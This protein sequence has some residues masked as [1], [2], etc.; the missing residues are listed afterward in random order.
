MVMVGLVTALAGLA[1]PLS[2]RK[3][4]VGSAPKGT[5]SLN[6]APFEKDL[7]FRLNRFPSA[8]SA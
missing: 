8:Q 3:T 2:V 5:E 4:F 7:E 6:L 1:T